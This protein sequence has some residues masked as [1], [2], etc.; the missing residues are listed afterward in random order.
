MALLEETKLFSTR[1]V[2]ERIGADTFNVARV[3]D[4]LGIGQRIGRVRA[5]RAQDVSTI[6]IGLRAAGLLKRP[7]KP[8][9]A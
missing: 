5:I 9:R 6:E 4:R 1:D 3:C 2:A 7:P 8:D